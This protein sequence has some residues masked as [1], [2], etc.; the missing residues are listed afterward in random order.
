M[1]NIALKI[2]SVRLF[3]VSLL[4]EKF[5]SLFNKNCMAYVYHY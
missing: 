3:S 4:S 5:Y 2:C 1:L